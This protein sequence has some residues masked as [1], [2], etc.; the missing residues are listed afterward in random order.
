[1]EIGDLCKLNGDELIYKITDI[2]TKNL[3]L[4]PDE[5]TTHQIIERFYDIEAIE[6]STI[7]AKNIPIYNLS[8]FKD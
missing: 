7:K 6:D 1:M 2:K 3:T 4:K 5:K 8:E